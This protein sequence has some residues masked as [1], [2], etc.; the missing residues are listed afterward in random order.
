MIPYPNQP[1][2]TD[3]GALVVL[4]HKGK[5]KTRQTTQTRL[6]FHLFRDI[7][8]WFWN[9]NLNLFYLFQNWTRK[10]SKKWQAWL[11]A[12]LQKEFLLIGEKKYKIKFQIRWIGVCLSL[13]S[14]IFQL[15]VSLFI[16]YQSKIKKYFTH[17][18]II[19]K[20]SFWCLNL[21]LSNNCFLGSKKTMNSNGYQKLTKSLSS[22]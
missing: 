12:K 3:L 5:H 15:K 16:D 21:E 17:W 6:P 8:I 1:R 11:E 10:I 4:F 7:H 9:F 18:L 22:S 20:G 2:G 14:C 19:W 13:W